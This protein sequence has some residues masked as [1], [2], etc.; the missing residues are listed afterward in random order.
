L[1]ETFR[2]GIYDRAPLP[3]WSTNRITL[4]GDAAHAMVPHLCQGANQSIE[5]GF[6]LAV[7]LQDVA[8]EEIPERLRVYEDLRRERTSRV[9]KQTRMADQ[10]YHAGD[11]SSAETSRQ[12]AGLSDDYWLADYDAE[13]EAMRVLQTHW[14]C[15]PRDR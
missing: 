1:D 11:E 2:W 6:V 4:L 13:R 10:I 9:Q 7:L 8:H 5:D 12:L 14:R 15:D 3:R